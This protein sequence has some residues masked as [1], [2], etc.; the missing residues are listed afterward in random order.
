M[1][2]W[3]RA[4]PRVLVLDNRDFARKVLVRMLHK[5]GARDV[6]QARDPEDAMVKMCLQAGVD[7]VLC[8]L[9][10]HGHDRMEFLSNASCS[11]MVRAV[12][13][14]G[15]LQPQLH[16]ALEQMETLAG[17]H[18]LGVMREPIQFRTLQLMLHRY[19]RTQT[20]SPPSPSPSRTHRI[21]PSE[22]EVRRGLALGEFRAWYQPQVQLS[23]RQVQC[24]E[25]LVRW[26]HPNLGVLLP[27]D[28]IAAVL[29]YKLIDQ[30]FLQLLEQGLSLLGVLRKQ[31]EKLGLAF[32]LHA[33]QLADSA[34]IQHIKHALDQHGFNGTT[35][36]FELGENGLL[37][38]APDTHENLLRLRLLGCGLSIDNFGSGFSSLKLLCKLPLT[39]IKL[40][41][42]F[43]QRLDI[44]SNQAMVISMQALA[45]SLG[46]SMVI[47]GVSSPQILDDLLKLGCEIGQGFN[48][49]SPMN[50]HTLLQWFKSGTHVQ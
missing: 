49:A 24:V 33:T 39:Q 19:E 2:G 10:S 43:V 21:L 22:D 42:Q 36:V 5:M 35:L 1:K 38:C 23:S 46:L 15:E 8:D 9:K 31:G 25:V 14:Y 40:D 44:Q 50:G 3:T 29:A 45:R 28:F 17:L 41:G 26:E 48:L 20:L 47:E 13:L 18:L 27:G 6:L 16:R 7:I 30:M 12:A 32:N 4:F 37:G 11:G 34:L